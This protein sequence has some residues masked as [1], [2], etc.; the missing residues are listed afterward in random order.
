MSS[1]SKIVIFFY[2]YE[3]LFDYIRTF[4]NDLYKYLYISLFN[5]YSIK[6]TIE[7]FMKLHE[8]F[9]IGVEGLVTGLYV[10]ACSS[11]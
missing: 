6:L 1:F 2:L 10:V 3:H 9:L 11:S 7:Y 5:M 4:L 8:I